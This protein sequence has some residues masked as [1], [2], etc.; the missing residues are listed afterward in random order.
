MYYVTSW[1]E[2]S[3][4]RKLPLPCPVYLPCKQEVKKQ[5]LK[6]VVQFDQGCNSATTKRKVVVNPC[7]MESTLFIVWINIMKR[8]IFFN[9][10]TEDTSE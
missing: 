7:G 8:Y 2:V 3:V 10:S 4:P 6:R 9:S 5:P 1:T